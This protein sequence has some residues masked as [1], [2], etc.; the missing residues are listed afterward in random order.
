MGKQDLEIVETKHD[1]KWFVLY[2]K[3]RTEKKVAERLK[4]QGFTVFCP[5][6]IERRQ[7]SDRIKKVEV[8]YFRSYVFVQCTEKEMV[9]VLETPGVVRRLYWLGRP[10]VI[11][12]G[13]MAEVQQFFNA[14]ASRNITYETYAKGEEVTIQSGTLRNRKAVVL[15]NDKSTVTLSLPALGAVF[16][17]TLS[18]ENIEKIR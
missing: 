9:V 2:V 11:R 5:T 3:S 1:M 6:K 16:K 15:I 12:A 13:E 10:A 7:W 8:P 14:N 18:K 17:V 4:N